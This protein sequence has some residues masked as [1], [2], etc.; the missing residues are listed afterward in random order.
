MLYEKPEDGIHTRVNLYNIQ[1]RNI[2]IWQSRHT[3]ISSCSLATAGGMDVI[4]A[5]ITLHTVHTCFT[6]AIVIDADAVSCPSKN[7]EHVSN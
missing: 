5:G 2:N 3:S 1:K 6:V 7:Y 4:P